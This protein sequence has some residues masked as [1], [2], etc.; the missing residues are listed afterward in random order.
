MTNPYGAVLN[1]G[2]NLMVIAPNPPRAFTITPNQGDVAGGTTVT[3]A[4]G[5]LLGLTGVTFGGV[6][7]T[8]LH[9]VDDTQATVVTPAHARGAVDVVATDPGGSH[10]QTGGFTYKGIPEID[11]IAP[12]TGG[13]AGNTIVTITGVNLGN[14][15]AVTF[16]GTPGTSLAPGPTSLTVHTPAHAAGAVDVVVTNPDG[17]DTALAGYTYT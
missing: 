1:D 11:E 16:G 3:L 17:S 12:A 6:A 9:V 4:G 8:S 13:A 14:V 5:G 10:T 15:S 2:L 7:G